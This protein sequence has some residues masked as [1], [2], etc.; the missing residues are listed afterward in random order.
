M[1]YG[2]VLFVIYMYDVQKRGKMKIKIIISFFLF[3]S[4]HLKYIK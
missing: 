2:F 1:Y 4:L 3:L